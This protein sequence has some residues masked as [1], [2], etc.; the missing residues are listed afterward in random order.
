MEQFSKEE[1]RNMGILLQKV[2]ITGAE[3]TTVAI[4]L[5]RIGSFL[6]MEAKSVKKDEE[7]PKGK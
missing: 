6:E 4:L 7:K 5:Q 3:A 2:T 1:L